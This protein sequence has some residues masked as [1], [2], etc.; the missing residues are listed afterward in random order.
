[1][2]LLTT[3]ILL[4]F[5][6]VLGC[7]DNEV[8][9]NR[10]DY[11]IK[12]ETGYLVNISFYSRTNG[13][14]NYDSPK[15]LESNGGQITNKVEL[16]IEFDDSE[17]YPKLAFSSDSVKV[18]FNNEKIYTN[19]FNSMTNTFSEPINRNLFKHSNYENLGNEQYL[20]KITQEDYENAQPCNEN[21]N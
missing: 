21:C 6:S 17:D 1:M 4:T 19:V 10:R 11:T 16:S 5:L 15:T 20:F 12:N 7:T 18:I 2:K 3:G 13:T 14:L 9:M 8:D